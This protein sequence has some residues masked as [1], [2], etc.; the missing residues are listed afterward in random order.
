MLTTFLFLSTGRNIQI[1]ELTNNKLM[2]DSS[3]IGVENISLE[4]LLIELGDSS[5]PHSLEKYDKKKFNIGKDL[6]KNGR[7]IRNGKKTKRISTFFVCIDCHNIGREFNLLESQSS[8]DR[9]NF[10]KNNFIP[11]LPGSTFYG[12]YNRTSFYNDDYVK[13][14]G[15]LVNK[16]SNNLNE[17][18]QVCAK[19]CSSG[20]YLDEWELEAIMHYFKGNELKINDLDLN[21][22]ILLDIENVANL[23]HNQKNDLKNKINS[24]YRKFYSATFLPAMDVNIR[25]YGDG[26]NVENGKFI[27]NKSCLHC[28]ANSRVTYLNLGNDK[29]SAEMFEKNLSNYSD[30]SLYQIIRYGTYPKAGRKQYMPLFTKEKMSDDQIND[31]VSYIKKLSNK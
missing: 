19:Y 30:K 15:D 27:Y 14:Y 29:L 4:D 26:G 13:K 18:I 3:S 9:L 5:Y 17:A 23:D 1:D 21:Y 2:E 25:K 28:H 10:A 6:I 20:R 24:F 11:Y 7:T 22:E 12:I 16:A 8:L 31:L